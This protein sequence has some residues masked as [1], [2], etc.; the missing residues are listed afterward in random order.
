MLPITASAVMVQLQYILG[1][2]R[3][4]ASTLATMISIVTLIGARRMQMIGGD[5]CQENFADKP[6]RT[7]SLWN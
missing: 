4:L 2:Y 1:I 7:P 3:T 6:R 5:D